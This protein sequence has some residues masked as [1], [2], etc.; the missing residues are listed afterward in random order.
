M[1]SG[2]QQSIETR[3]KLEAQQQE[4]KS[5][6]KVIEIFNT[7]GTVGDMLKRWTGIRSTF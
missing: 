4:N 5:V 6:Q 3:Q 7:P 2:L 1:A